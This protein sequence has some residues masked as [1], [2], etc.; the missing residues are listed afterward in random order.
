MALTENM[1]AQVAMIARERGW[2]SEDHFA[3]AAEE[4]SSRAGGRYDLQ[5]RLGE[6]GAAEVYRAW[7]RQLKRPVALKLL[8]ETMAASES[9]RRRFDREEAI[10]NVLEQL[11][12]AKYAKE[13][14]GFLEEASVQLNL[15]RLQVRVMHDG[16]V[17][18]A[19]PYGQF[20]QRLDE[21][22]RQLGGWMRGTDGRKT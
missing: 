16:G 11:V 20:C 12:R 17:L 21:V 7:D 2:L 18:G 22:G 5:E 4:A 15:A 13:K 19:V 3:A 1:L 9:V 6:G 8:R 10:L 14:R